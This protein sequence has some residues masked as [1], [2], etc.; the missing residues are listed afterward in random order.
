MGGV[1]GFVGLDSYS[2]ELA[3][4]LLRSGFK[5]Q[6]FEVCCFGFFFFFCW[7]G[8][9]W[10]NHVDRF[11][12]FGTKHV[13]FVGSVVISKYSVYLSGFQL[14]YTFISIFSTDVKLI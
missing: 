14:F 13:K 10:K 9:F 8:M 6:A 5:V 12:L 3:S 4:S 2:F 1:V 11:K 7:I